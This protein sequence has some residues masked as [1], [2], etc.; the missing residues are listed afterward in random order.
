MRA[1]CV[2]AAC[3]SMYVL[4]LHGREACRLLA[5]PIMFLLSTSTWP[6]FKHGCDIGDDVPRPICTEILNE[7]H[8]LPSSAV[9]TCNPRQAK[10]YSR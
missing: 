5:V 10:R 7:E 4:P 9:G 3:G 6:Y 2:C 8:D 1:M